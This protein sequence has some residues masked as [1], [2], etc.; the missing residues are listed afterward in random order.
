MSTET[1]LIDK[2][3]R[4]VTELPGLWDESDRF[5][6]TAIA[7]SKLLTDTLKLPNFINALPEFQYEALNEAKR[8]GRGVRIAS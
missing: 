5:V 2:E 1:R 6:E 7:L 8:V 3:G 4:D